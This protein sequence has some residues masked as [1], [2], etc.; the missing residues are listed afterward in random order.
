MGRREYTFIKSQIAY[1][2]HRNVKGNY[3][4]FSIITILHHCFFSHLILMGILIY[5]PSSEGASAAA[6]VSTYSR[7]HHGL[8]QHRQE[9]GNAAHGF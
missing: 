7:M 3:L 4:L 6:M 8:A 9:R 2:Y 5:H 1:S